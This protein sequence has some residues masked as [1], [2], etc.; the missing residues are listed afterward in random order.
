MALF[1]VWFLTLVFVTQDTLYKDLMDVTGISTN[2]LLVSLFP[3]AK[4]EQ[5]KKPTVCTKVGDARCGLCVRADTCVLVL[6]LTPVSNNL[7]DDTLV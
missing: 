1:V 4:Q 3:D 5:A 2:Q 6:V 7:T